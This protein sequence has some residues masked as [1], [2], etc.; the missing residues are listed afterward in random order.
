[1]SDT[2]DYFKQKVADVRQARFLAVTIG[3]LGSCIAAAGL[4]LRNLML[5]IVGFPILFSALYLSV[6][7]ELQRLH[8]LDVIEKTAP[9]ET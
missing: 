3:A 1:M 8:Y 9:Q 6:H 2:K 7:Y 5:A 4:L